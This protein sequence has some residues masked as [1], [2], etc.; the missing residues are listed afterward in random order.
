MGDDV[1]VN[2]KKLLRDAYLNK[3][4]IPH[5]NIN[6]LEWCKY[7]LEECEKNNSPVILGVSESAQKYMGGYNTVVSMINNLISFLNINI[8]VVIHLDHGSTVEECIKAIDAGFTSVMYDGSKLDIRENIKNLKIVKEY[9]DMYDVSVEAEIGHIE[10]AKDTK[11]DSIAYANIDDC[12]KLVE[13]TGVDSIAPA[14]GNAHGLY[15]YPV[16]INFKL[17]N[18][19]NSKVH[20]PLVLHGGS[21]ISDELI[22]KLIAQ[23]ISKININTELQS[24]WAIGVRKYLND[25]K[26]A[27]DPRKIIE[28]GQHLMK[29]EIKHKLI[30][31]KSIDKA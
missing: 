19:I 22:E 26:D 12:I 11:L 10:D 27:I 21:G 24:K 9:A 2:S 23:G 14:I 16:N 5:F 4:A 8:P 18:D 6:N 30:L 3:Y 29:E 28:S 1:I 31:F 17:L 13:E 7:I 15:K 20:I 25:N